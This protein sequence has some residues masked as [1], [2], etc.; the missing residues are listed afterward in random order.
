VGISEALVIA[1]LSWFLLGPQELFRIA[2]QVGAWLGE[3]R[4][5]VAQA[6]KQYESALDDESTRKAI[7]GIRETQRTVVELGSQWRSVADS[8]RDP[9][10]LGGVLEKATAKVD[11][12]AAESKSD[13]EGA[14]KTTSEAKGDSKAA[15]D[16]PSE[17]DSSSK[18]ESAAELQAKI[19]KSKEDVSDLWYDKG[20]LKGKDD[21]EEASSDSSSTL[22]SRGERMLRR[23]DMQLDELSTL[24]SQV[25]EV[26]EG[27]LEE[28][29]ALRELITFEAEKAKSK[30]ESSKKESVR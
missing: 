9:L 7:E 8:M 13:K 27:L 19:A 23:L 6:A 22:S 21:E 15:A 25:E 4:A 10:N 12:V 5:F 18:G 20:M 29:V 2:K 24:L 30:V 17:A 1:I 14:G 11:Q 16:K 3:L 26:K 28:R